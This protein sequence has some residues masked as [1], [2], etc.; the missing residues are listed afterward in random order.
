MI[1]PSTAVGTGLAILGSKD[2]LNKLLGP[3][4]DYV[5][6][7]AAGFIK[8]CNINLD[9]IF[10]KA[11]RKLGTKIED[12]GSVSPR[13]L[14]HIIDDGRFC[15]D[16]LAAEYYGGLL[17]GSREPTGKD[18]RCLPYISR[19]KAMSVLQIR[20]HFAIYYSLL[21]LHKDSNINLGLSSEVSKAGLLLPHE[22]LASLFPPQ[23][24]NRYWGTMTHVVVGLSS[25][26]L[27]RNYA[28]GSKN[29]LEGRFPS[30]DADGVYVEPTFFGAELFMWALGV[31]YATAHEFFKIDIEEI[32][33]VI[34]IPASARRK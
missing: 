23:Q 4:A 31:E 6:G 32:D 7:E 17:A 22:F 15:E 14:R 9:G 21:R 34:A 11:V 1:D 2:V 26:D 3:T 24:N 27:I 30:A 8:K 33:P 10:Q 20:A 16:E 25:D 19:V 29:D 13:V 12:P 28:Y 18:D 5:G